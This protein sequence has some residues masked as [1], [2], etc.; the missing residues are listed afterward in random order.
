[1]SGGALKLAL[2]RLFVVAVALAC[3]SGTFG[4]IE[5]QI[6]GWRSYVALREGLTTLERVQPSG[7]TTDVVLAVPYRGAQLRVA[8]PVDTA[9]LAA[10][11]RVDGSAL[12]G[13]DP[14]VRTSSLRALFVQQRDDP[15]VS[16]MAQR[17]GELRGTLH[18]S[19]DDYVDMV[20][21]AVQT[22]PYGSL[23]ESTFMPVTTVAGNRGVCADKSLLLACVLARLGYD[24]GVFVFPSQAHVAV[25][26]RGRGPGLNS[27]GY[28][29]IET[30][31]AS[32]VGEVD[33]TL[34]APG[35]IY[36]RP[37]L[38]LAGGSTI[39]TRDLQAEFVAETLERIRASHNDQP[40]VPL[41]QD[42]PAA[43]GSR[44]DGHTARQ[45]ELVRWIDNRRDWPEDAFFLLT[46]AG[47]NH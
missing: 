47:L 46:Q 37:Q 27:T 3:A 9:Y 40:A 29:L 10:A 24:V 17:L 1:V 20:A 34:R 28:T 4:Y 12:F 32:Y 35:P 42:E 8:V 39:Y 6:P 31:R 25:A 11:R 21:R 41:A 5:R 15:F 30:T 26:V 43:K 19:D 16:A 2:G 7:V 38:V 13:T 45:S 22:I 14:V 18:L 23:H 36:K 33:R 44:S